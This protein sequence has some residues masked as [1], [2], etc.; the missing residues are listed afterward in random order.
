[1]TVL[2]F[3]IDGTLLQAGGAG[4]AAMEAALAELFGTTRPVTGISTAGRTDHA[5]T[6]DLFAFHEILHDETSWAAFLASYFTRLPESLRTLQGRIL[7]GVEVLLEQLSRRDDLLLGVL[8]GN[9]EQG[10]RVKLQHFGIA[11]YFSF[12]AYG[13]LHADRNDVARLAWDHI[14]QRRPQA[15]AHDVWVIGD[16]PNDIRCGK[17]IGAKTLAVATGPFSQEALMAAGA[18]VVCSDLSDTSQIV[19][20]LCPPP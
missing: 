8:T 5:I 20:Y 4:Q 16:T 18:D 14:L 1:M 7:P 2:L 3:D 13:D 11:H 12:G 6:R 9:F 17:A 15:M 19:S 10:A